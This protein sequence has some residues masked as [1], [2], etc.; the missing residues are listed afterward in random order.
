MALCRRV[1]LNQLTHFQHFPLDLVDGR[2]CPQWGR[3]AFAASHAR[4][5]P[6]SEL[7]S[8]TANASMPIKAAVANSS[9]A[10]EAPRRKEN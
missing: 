4:T 5:M 6:A 2:P 1:L 9:S 8:V 10:E 3:V 7:R